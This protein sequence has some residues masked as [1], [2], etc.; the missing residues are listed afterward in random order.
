MGGNHALVKDNTAP[1][2]DPRG[3]VGGRHLT[4]RGA[5][6]GWILRQG[7]GVQV[8]DAENA[9]VVVLQGDPVADGAEIVAEMQVAGRLN[10]GKDAV[11]STSNLRCGQR[12]YP[13]GTALVKPVAGATGPT[14]HANRPDQARTTTVQT[15]QARRRSAPQGRP[16]AARR[17]RRASGR[18]PTATPPTPLPFRQRRGQFAAGCGGYAGRTRNAGA[19]SAAREV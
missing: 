17:G 5:Q 7:Q 14:R 1:R 12:C 18:A 15:W 3:D 6:L 19:G 16:F 13:R 4:R 2:V 11:H 10:A 9:V 8:D